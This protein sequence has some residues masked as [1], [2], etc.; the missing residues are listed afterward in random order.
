MS[1][2]CEE[3]EAKECEAS[4]VM[5]IFVRNDSSAHESTINTMAE[6]KTEKS[7]MWNVPLLIVTENVISRT[8]NS[9][10]YSKPN[11]HL[12]FISK[13]LNQWETNGLK[14]QIFVLNG[15]S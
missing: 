4:K 15:H 8:G 10:F 12:D 13:S 2:Q 7:L 1:K 5:R 3:G 14:F 11:I 6:S 9:T